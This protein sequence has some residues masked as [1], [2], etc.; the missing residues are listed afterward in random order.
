MSTAEAL[1]SLLRG[2]KQVLVFTGAGISTG[3][4]IPD[5]RGPAGVWTRRQPVTLQQFVASDAARREYWEMKLEAW[6]AFRD[7]RPSATHRALVELERR[8]TV[9][10]IVTQ[11]VDGLHQ[12]AGTSR[13]RLVEL[14]GT[15]RR[16][17]CLDC[18]RREPP[19]R[20]M[21]EYRATQ[22][23][24]RCPS[25]GGFMRPDVV[26][27]GEQ[28][29]PALLERAFGAAARADLAL[30]L[31]SS[32]VVTP[33][34]QVPLHSA[35]RGTPYVIVNQGETPHDALATLCIDADVG[36]VLASAV[37]LL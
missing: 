34:A 17:R 6:P 1:A 30:A 37:S 11:N 18:A 28:L 21:N 23:P 33:A 5:F 24:P 14:H 12:V 31:G 15:N 20:C 3:S 32:L 7:A 9:E 8:G 36:E 16:V 27:F 25:C 4:G 29:D 19:E 13:D 10:L 26:M 35:R 22:A 2:A